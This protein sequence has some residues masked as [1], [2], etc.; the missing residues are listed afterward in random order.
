[1]VNSSVHVR[2]ILLWKGSIIN[3]FRLKVSIERGKRF[4][5]LLFITF[6]SIF[7]LI[8][9]SCAEWREENEEKGRYF[10]Y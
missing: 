5:L 4:F 10:Y 6:I 3:T 9:L 8:S 1:M 2:Y 7:V